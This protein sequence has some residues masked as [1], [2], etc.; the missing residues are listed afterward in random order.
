MKIPCSFQRA[1]ESDFDGFGSEMGAKMDLKGNQNG[2]EMAPK[3][4][5]DMVFDSELVF[6]PIFNA[7][8]DDSG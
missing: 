8:S 2:P 1:L 4:I 3:R 7:F 5:S 6:E